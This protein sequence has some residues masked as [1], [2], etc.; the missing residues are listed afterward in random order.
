MYRFT[1]VKVFGK[2]CKNSGR[3]VSA[4]DGVGEKGSL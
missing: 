2:A 4:G 1:V 3:Q